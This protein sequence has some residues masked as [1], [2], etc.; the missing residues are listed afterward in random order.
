M[1]V[2][3]ESRKKPKLTTIIVNG[4]ARDVEGNSVTFEQVVKLAF[5][6]VPE[7]ENIVIAVTYTGAKGPKREGLLNPGESVEIKN[8]TSFDV[9]VNNKS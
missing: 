8:H 3:E 2:Q 9:K 5:D 7:G 1:Q 4:R 6:P